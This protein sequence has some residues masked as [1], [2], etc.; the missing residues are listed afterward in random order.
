MKVRN[1][2]WVLCVTGV[3]MIAGAI[4]MRAEV[5]PATEDFTFRRVKVGDHKGPRITVQIDPAEQARRLAAAKKPEPY[6]KPDTEVAAEPGGGPTGDATPAA[7]VSNAAYGWFWDT[8]SPSLGAVQ[9]RFPLALATLSQGPAGARVAA[10]RLQHMQD[11]VEEYGTDILKAT[12][13]TEVSPALVL[14]VI[15]IESAGRA[16]AVSSAGAQGLMQLIPATAERFGV[17]DAKDPVQN[18]KGGV[19]YLQWL[20]GEFNYRVRCKPQENG[21]SQSQS[22]SAWACAVRLP[23]AAVDGCD[24]DAHGETGWRIGE[25]ANWLTG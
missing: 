6:K 9:G 20:M 3:L 14:A 2:L 5:I 7:P 13:G 15:G 19:A 11:V 10:P 18:I 21:R 1:G 22:G 25:L 8:V 17:T 23:F 4:P 24:R 16:D 12:I